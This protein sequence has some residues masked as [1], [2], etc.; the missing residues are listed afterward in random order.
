MPQEVAQGQGTPREPDLEP[1]TA[2]FLPCLFCIQWCV[3]MR[4]PTRVK[5]SILG[6][7]GLLIAINLALPGWV[8]RLV[9]LTA[10]AACAGSAA[11]SADYFAGRK[12][13]RRKDWVAAIAAF[14]RYAARQRAQPWRQWAGALSYSVYS[15]DAQAI[16]HNA[17]GAVHLNNGQLERAEASFNA[18]I[19]SDPGYGVPHLNLALVAAQ[20]GDTDAAERHARQAELLGVPKKRVRRALQAGAARG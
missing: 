16:A 12:A 2:V 5:L 18:A 8:A 11:A 20:R 3:T 1:V 14:E 4:R 17:I 6:G 9:A 10:L 13:L 15:F 19:S 7:C